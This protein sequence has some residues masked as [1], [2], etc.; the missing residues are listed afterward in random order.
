[1]NDTFVYIGKHSGVVF[2]DLEFRLFCRVQ[3]AP[4]LI[5]GALWMQLWDG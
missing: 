3:N 5:S 4:D 2:P 1:M